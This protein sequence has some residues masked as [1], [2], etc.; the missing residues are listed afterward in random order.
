MLAIEESEVPEVI[1]WLRTLGYRVT[2]PP[3]PAAVDDVHGLGEALGRVVKTM[4]A[5]DP[6]KLRRRAV[7][8]SSE[9]FLPRRPP[10]LKIGQEVTDP[11]TGK[12]WRVTD[13]GTRTFVAV[14]VSDPKVVA[15]PSWANGPPY[16]IVEHVW[17]ETWY[18]V[19]RGV[20]GI[21]WD[22]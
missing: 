6:A 11:T 1:A 13:V 17:D 9:E 20:P 5:P 4:N 14:C 15:D 3:T 22:K 10:R 8:V 19:L 7:P 21:E 18:G 12:R 16:A 2:P